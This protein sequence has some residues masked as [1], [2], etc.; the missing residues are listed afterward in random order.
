MSATTNNGQLGEGQF[1]KLPNLT[2]EKKRP[3]AQSL[4]KIREELKLLPAATNHDGSPA[5][6]IQDP[7]NNRFFRIGWLDFE[8][9]S[10]WHYTFTQKMI[11][12]VS[13]ETTLTIYAEDIK[14]LVYFLDQNNLLQADDSAKVNRLSQRANE[15]KS[16]AFNWLL[17]YYLFFR[18]PLVRPQVFLA[19]LLQF[20]SW[21]YT[22]T[23]ALIICIIT[24]LGLF[25]VM[26]QWEVFASTFVDQLSWQGVFGFTLALIFAKTL[27][28]MGHA[29]TATRY[30]VR[31]AHMGV[32]FLV[33]FPMLY[34]DTSESWKLSNHKQRLAIASAGIITELALAGL[35]TLAWSLSPEGSL[36]SALFYL[37][38]TSW[39]LTLAV[40]VSPF[41]RFDGY[42]ILTDILDMPNL[43][44]RSGA[45][46]KAWMRN[47]L[48][49]FNETYAE[50]FPKKTNRMMIAFAI[51]TWL[52]R[53]L[54]YLGIAA[55][56]YFYFFKILGIFL[57]VVEILWFVWRPFWTEMKVWKAR[58]AEIKTNRKLLLGALLLG[59]II[60]GFIPFQTGVKG[61]AWVHS[62]RQQTIYSPLPGRLVSIADAGAVAENQALFV[63]ESPDLSVSADKANIQAKTREQELIGLIGL[64]DGEENRAQLQLQQEQFLAE[65]NMYS[66]DI[67]RLSI[68]APFAGKLM[69]VDPLL[70]TGV[71]VK[72]DQPLGVV[73]DPN[74]WFAHV[75]INEEDVKRIAVDNKVKLHQATSLEIQHGKVIEIDTTK[76]SVLP[77]PIMDAKSGGSVVTLDMQN[78]DTPKYA[79][80]DTLYRV[81]VALDTP[82]PQLQMETRDAI[83]EG[84]RSAWLP[85]VFKRIAAVLV[86]ES[87]F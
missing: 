43:H 11:A 59:A 15:A 61:S 63:L 6:M 48:L 56:V 30:G 31:V 60:V 41:M 47:T 75:L 2:A 74:N 87:G 85:S 68:S 25:L 44:E 4:P 46:A 1:G 32:A 19:K 8:I 3:P 50:H 49:G 51:V 52:Y 26:R 39:I 27:H 76:A 13:D 70:A 22:P 29:L 34:T 83:I 40:N 14:G 24:L 21:I 79:P 67:S 38:T 80:R 16:S 54:L 71:W 53:F 36:K 69:D 42:F 10:R 7:V 64:A 12:S 37:A 58:S 57:M 81:R 82:P 5:W 55:L 78:K 28:E 18:V 23:F 73:V 66:D 86:R 84:E 72:P 9:L 45:L 65:Q 62:A 17:H 35:A 77:H 20:I 33:M